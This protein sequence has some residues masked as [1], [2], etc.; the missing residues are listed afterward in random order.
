[1]DSGRAGPLT[2][3]VNTT[4]FDCGVLHADAKSAQFSGGHVLPIFLDARQM[5]CFYGYFRPI[6]P[7]L[8]TRLGSV[9]VTRDV[10]VCLVES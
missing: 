7:G 3:R 4:M 10:L 1:M 5:H 8:S 9:G 2:Y 6:T